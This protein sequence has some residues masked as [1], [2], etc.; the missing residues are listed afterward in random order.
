MKRIVYSLLLLMLLIS[1][2]NKSEEMTNAVP[3]IINPHVNEGDN[4]T[5]DEGV[6]EVEENTF[7]VPMVEIPDNN[8]IQRLQDINLD[9]DV[10]EEQI[11]LTM[12]KDEDGKDKLKL[13]IADYN[14]DMMRYQLSL[15]E[16]I[17]PD[18][19]EGLSV[20]LQDL[21]GNQLNEV[22]ITG[23]NKQGFQTLDVFSIKTQGGSAGLTYRRIAQLVVNGTID[24]ETADRSQ[25][26][27]SGQMTWESFPIITEET[28][29][30]DDENLDL[31][32]TV[33]NWNKAASRYQPISVAK[34]PGVTIKEENLKKLYRGDLDD[35]KAFLSGPWH[36]VSDSVGEKQPFLQDILY[37]Q[38]DEDQVIFTI[39]DIQEIY[40]WDD[41]YRTIFKGIYIQSQNI[42]IQSLRRDILITVEDMDSIKVK[43][44]GTTEWGGYYT[45][46]SQSL[47][48][49]LVHDEMLEP[50][51]ELNH[52]SG[53]FKGSRG[54]EFYLDYPFFTEKNVDGENRQG[55][56]TFFNL[57][58]TSILQLRYQRKNGLMDA[59][60]VYNVDFQI[61]EDSSRI[62]RTLT[63]VPGNLTVSGFLQE[64][65]ETLHI[66]QIEVMDKS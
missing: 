33:Y 51:E 63:L 5:N 61:T 32:K 64:S 11:I 13:F 50:I 44:Q 60:S 49:G 54:N 31:I 6:N 17:S 1:C 65:G 40:D 30:E 29:P 14:N 9:H 52:L 45:P 35:F 18:H 59:R 42:L 21:N 36:R 23:F 24:I 57:Y 19:M 37:F 38:P 55:V 15:E 20:H 34:V 47:Q 66:E 46:L 7:L 56:Y 53:L 27:K 28:N 22:L 2:R 48:Q 10:E 41:T 26:Y 12:V 16:M 25:E 58:G 3:R 39:D 43:I 62:I 4:T 8:H